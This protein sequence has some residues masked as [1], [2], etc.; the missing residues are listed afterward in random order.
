MQRLVYPAHDYR[1]HT[2]ST[3]GEEKRWNPR[4]TG[5]DRASFINLMALHL[6]DPKKMMEAIAANE[7]C[8]RLM[9]VTA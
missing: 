7:Q 5:R 8:G 4:F 1:G 2:V 3:I 9:Q 6:P